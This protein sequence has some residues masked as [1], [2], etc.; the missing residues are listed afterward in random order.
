M[1][2]TATPPFWAAAGKAKARSKNELRRMD[3]ICMENLRK[4]GGA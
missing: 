2:R 4:M 3:F 1:S